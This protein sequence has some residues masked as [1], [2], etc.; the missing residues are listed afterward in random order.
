MKVET[1]VYHAAEGYLPN[2][3][4]VSTRPPTHDDGKLEW[5]YNDGLLNADDEYPG[6]VVVIEGELADLERAFAG[7]VAGCAHIHGADDDTYDYWPSHFSGLEHIA[8]QLDKL[9]GLTIHI[10]IVQV[11]WDSIAFDR[12][13][14]DRNPDRKGLEAEKEYMELDIHP[15]PTADLVNHV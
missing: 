10:E 14:S 11:M 12:W 2:D 6:A 13:A 4:A 9:T 15:R 5:G 1:F 7:W 3:P 8:A